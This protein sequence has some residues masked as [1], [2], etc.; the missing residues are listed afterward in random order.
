MDHTDQGTR[1]ELSG[2]V[3][4]LP[5]LAP[6]TELHPG[7]RVVP[8][9]AADLG[10]VPVTPGLAA[11]LTPA[12]ICSVL[13]TGI[14]GGPE[15]T[16]RASAQLHTGPE[17]GFAHLTPGLLSLIEATSAT[18]PVAYLEADYTGRDGWQTAAA[19]RDGTILLGPLILGRSEAFVPRRAPIS[20]V[21]RLL[22]V[23]GSL[24]HDEFVVAGLGRCR[25]TVDWR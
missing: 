11:G 19:W 8:L 1:Y 13:R 10:L 5:V 22:G 9:D 17:S 2:V 16:G 7:V 6:L 21:L 3:G 23:S 15:S 24:R 14:D 20:Q 12:M 18:G 25:R 4:A